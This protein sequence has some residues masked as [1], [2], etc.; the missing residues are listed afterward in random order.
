MG[1]PLIVNISTAVAANGVWAGRDLPQRR[2]HCP[3]PSAKAGGSGEGACSVTGVT[4]TG[5]SGPSSPQ[6]QGGPGGHCPPQ[7][8][9]SVSLYTQAR[10]LPLSGGPGDPQDDLGSQIPLVQEGC[11]YGLEPSLETK[12][13]HKPNL[14]SGGPL[15]SRGPSGARHVIPSVNQRGSRWTS[16]TWCGLRLRDSPDFSLR[17]PLPPLLPAATVQQCPPRRPEC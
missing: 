13:P 3:H 12:Y 4:P 6:G 5:G 16:P 2:V 8:E 1:E 15:W 9:E 14:H 11:V 17:P 7:P 10:T